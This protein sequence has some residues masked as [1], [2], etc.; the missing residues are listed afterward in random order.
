M[1]AA[2]LK[3]AF[4]PTPSAAPIV[5]LPAIVVTLPEGVPRGVG[6]AD[7]PRD[8]E[9]V[10][11]DV[12]LGVALPDGVTVVLAVTV[13]GGVPLGVPEGVGVLVGEGVAEPEADGVAAAVPEPEGVIDADAPRVTEAVGDADT[14][15]LA[16]SVELGVALA[17]A[18]ARSL[19][20]LHPG[21]IYRNAPMVAMPHQHSAFPLLQAT[22]EYRG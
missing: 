21:F 22:P 9:A 14:V 17:L 12:L 1:P 18:G 4:E 5:P 19:N 7:R 16:L 8:T 11:L 13:A 2:L 6:D 10:A 20:E 3:L 15:E